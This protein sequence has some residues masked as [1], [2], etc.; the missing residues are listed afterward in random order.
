MTAD[1]LF[2]E[3]KIIL[4]CESVDEALKLYLGNYRKGWE[5]RIGSIVPTNTKQL[6]MWLT[7]GN[8][9]EPFK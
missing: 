6:R 3:H 5:S 9:N 4:G 8:L 7:T 1:N 2:D